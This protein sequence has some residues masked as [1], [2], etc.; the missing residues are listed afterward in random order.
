[1]TQKVHEQAAHHFAIIHL[2]EH[3]YVL[4]QMFLYHHIQES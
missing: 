2:P 1:M 4:L 3:T